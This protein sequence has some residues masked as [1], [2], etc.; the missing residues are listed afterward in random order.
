MNA[1]QPTTHTT[2]PAQG[3]PSTNGHV[4]HLDLT[5]LNLATLLATPPPEHRWVWDGYIEQ[6]TLTVLHGD[7]G[8]GK[9][10]LAGHLARAVAAGSQCLGRPITQGGVLIIDA[11]N[12]ID[13]IHRRL[14][15]LDYASVPADL[16][17]YYRARDVIFGAPTDVDTT[18][19]RIVIQTHKSRLVILDSQRGLWGGE[20]KDQIEIRPFYRRLQAIAEELDCAIVV[21]HHDRRT[22]SFSGSSDIHNS[23]DTRLHLERP[24]PEKPER[25]LHHAKARSSAEL[26]AAAYTFTFD[27]TLKLFTFTQPREPITDADQLFEALDD[28]DWLT[29]KEVA[30][31]AGIRESDA[32]AVLWEL[33]RSG[34]VQSFTGPPGRSSRAV[35]FR[36]SRP[37]R[38]CS[39]TREQS[40]AVDQNLPSA[41][42]PPSFTPPLGGEDGSSRQAE[43]LPPLLPDSDDAPYMPNPDQEL[44]F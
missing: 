14:H 13:E 8:T 37:T 33:A 32:K 23:A 44:P 36:K 1:D 43:L 7:G 15:A 12:P 31:R 21:I 19:L 9:S 40:G 27:H 22:G 28:T 5:H 39:Q 20:E 30:P 35:G 38:N 10:I 26:P 17:H 42:A 11:E 2:P 6:G 25:I 34:D 4:D 41:T 24:D 29:V 16:I 18:L 3:E